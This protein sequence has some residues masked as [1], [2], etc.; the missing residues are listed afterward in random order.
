MGELYVSRLF[1]DLLGKSERN[2]VNLVKNVAWQKIHHG[3]TENTKFAIHRDS[4]TPAPEIRCVSLLAV[5]IWSSLKGTMPSLAILPNS[6]LRRSKAYGYEG[7]ADHF[8]KS[9]IGSFRSVRVNASSISDLMEPP[10]LFLSSMSPC[11]RG[12]IPLFDQ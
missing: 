1:R 3:G 5:D 2:P 9:E 6:L 10:L 8:I 7:R 4:Q 11:L 12:K